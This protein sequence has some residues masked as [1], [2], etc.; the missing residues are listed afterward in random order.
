MS[1]Y[2]NFIKIAKNEL[3]ESEMIRF[4]NERFNLAGNELK[5]A[6]MF[7]DPD[8]NKILNAAKSY[9][10]G[11]YGM[12]EDMI[13]NYISSVVDLD[14]KTLNSIL[15]S[16]HSDCVSK[17]ESFSD[18]EKSNHVKDIVNIIS[19]Y[20][21]DLFNYKNL[22]NKKELEEYAFDNS[23]YSFDLEKLAD[24][25][26]ELYLNNFTSMKSQGEEIIKDYLK[27][28]LRLDKKNTLTSAY[29]IH[30]DCVEEIEQSKK[31]GTEVN[32]KDLKS[33]ILSEFNNLAFQIYS[34]YMLSDTKS[35]IGTLNSEM[36]G[37]KQTLEKVSKEEYLDVPY[38]DYIKYRQLYLKKL[39]EL[40]KNNATES[41]FVNYLSDINLKNKTYTDI[42]DYLNNL[43]NPIDVDKVLEKDKNL[44]NILAN[45][46]IYKD[47]I[48]ILYNDIFSKL[49]NVLQIFNS[50]MFDSSNFKFH[51]DVKNYI[52]EVQ[53]Y[54][55]KYINPVLFESKK[56]I[57][58]PFI[59]FDDLAKSDSEAENDAKKFRFDTISLV[60]G[61]IRIYDQI[62]D[63]RTFKNKN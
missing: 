7:I 5:F 9:L 61:W 47:R 16:I 32:I 50:S 57:N 55:K 30:T 6:P 2:D 52:E 25:I 46:R 37:L 12:A 34:K 59:E 42:V 39:F 60:N 4:F 45:A 1:Y 3:D 63:I 40:F 27:S 14:D 38:K 35:S 31:S 22:Y 11:S 24:I 17:I 23:L 51:K 54:L 44:Q 29:R 21:K 19:K 10:N 13:R 26:A 33:I 8:D 41:D 15:S 62:Q 49:T 20:L 53:N 36:L 18:T 43:S 48:K 56:E 28:F 58:N